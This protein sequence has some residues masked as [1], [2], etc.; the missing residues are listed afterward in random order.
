[1]NQKLIIVR[2][3][4]ASGKTTIG[5]NL[6]DF[7]KKIVWF[8]TDNLKPFFSNYEKSHLDEVMDVCIATLKHL[9]DK[10][11]SVIYEGIFIKTEYVKRAVDLGRSKN[12]PVVIYQLECSLKTLQERDRTRKGIKEGCREMLGNEVIA[13]IY[14]KIEQTP[15]EGAIKL[16][17]EEKSI[18]E[19]LDIIRKNFAD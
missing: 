8:K 13:S 4:P 15:I 19:C 7:D 5:E 12:I 3:A 14:E 17:T 11:Y 1:M 10:E 6:R 16:N 18:E 9:L 2:G